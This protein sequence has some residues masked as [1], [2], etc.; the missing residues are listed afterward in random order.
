M[1]LGEM[2]RIRLDVGGYGHCKP[3]VP[4]R[5]RSAIRRGAGDIGRPTAR[6]DT[7]RAMSQENVELLRPST[8]A[9]LAGTS[10]SDREGMLTKIAE[11]WDPDIEMDASEVP[12]LDISGVYRGKEEV[13]QF[14]REWLSAWDALEFEYEL[15]G[16]GDRVVQLIDLRMRGRSTGIEMPFGKHAWVYKLRDG[17]VVHQKLYMSHAEALEAVGLSE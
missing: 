3:P 9:F 1:P 5:T 7:A 2:G 11:L 15:V 16:A 6:R 10:E 14:W 17:L 12:V 13:R 4:K 8:E